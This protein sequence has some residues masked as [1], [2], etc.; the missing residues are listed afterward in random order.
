MAAIISRTARSIPTSAAR[1]TMLWPMF[2]SS[3]ESICAIAWTFPLIVYYVDCE[4]TTE[5][6]KG[7]VGQLQITVH[8]ENL[9]YDDLAAYVDDQTRLV[10]EGRF[11]SQAGQLAWRADTTSW[12]Y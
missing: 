7:D 4:T 8:A 2:S 10:H 11:D 6:P 1:A 12:R 3:T 9:F 5:V